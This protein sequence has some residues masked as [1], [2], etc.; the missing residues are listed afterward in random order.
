VSKPELLLH[1]CCAPCIAGVYDTL[2]NDYHVRV[3]YYNP[4]IA[5]RSEYEKRLGEVQSYSAMSGFELNIGAYEPGRWTSAVKAHRFSGERSR[6]CYE[7]IRFRL[8]ESFI[9][10]RAAECSI[11]AT[12]LSVS[13]H[14]DAEMI[15]SAGA[16][17]GK[18][19][20]MGFL[21]ADF[22]QNGGYRRSVEQSRKLGFY[23]QNYCGCIWSLMERRKDSLWRNMAMNRNIA[24]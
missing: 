4:N 15:N 3:H 23:R 2:I 17:L 13:P 22:K 1:S 19:Y 9:L 10:A 24:S 11:V 21:Q 18:K 8:E 20:S 5:P 14:K 7:C 6:R 12:T 16:E